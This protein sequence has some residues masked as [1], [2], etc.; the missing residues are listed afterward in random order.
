MSGD[1]FWMGRRSPFQ[2][3]MGVERSQEGYMEPIGWLETHFWTVQSLEGLQGL[4]QFMTCRVGALFR[5][6][7]EAGHCDVVVVC[8]YGIP[9]YE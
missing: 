9:A 1:R 6:D 4:A 5:I 3:C 8:F 7:P 2:C